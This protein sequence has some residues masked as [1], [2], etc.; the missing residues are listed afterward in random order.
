VAT[1][2]E[3][4]AVLRDFMARCESMHKRRLMQSGDLWTLG[5]FEMTVNA[6]GQMTTETIAPDEEDYR[7]F[8]MDFR[9]FIMQKEVNLGRVMNI[10]ARRLDSPD[11]LANNQRNQAQRKTALK[12][13]LM[14]LHINETRYTAEDYLDAFINGIYFHGGDPRQRALLGDALREGGPARFFAERIVT[15]TILEVTKLVTF[16]YNVTQEALDNDGLR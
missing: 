4:I 10:L 12:G 11:L 9:F 8:L 16:T 3:D 7:S 15:N 1:I 5:Q 13:S 2:E 6:D 14:A